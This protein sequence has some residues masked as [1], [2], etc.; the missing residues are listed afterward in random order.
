MDMQMKNL[1]AIAADERR[2]IRQQTT[3]LRQQLAASEVRA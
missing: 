3:A 1:A 2:D